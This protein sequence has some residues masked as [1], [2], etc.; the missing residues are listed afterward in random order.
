LA[1]YD[2]NRK[3]I[4]QFLQTVKNLKIIPYD[5]TFQDLRGV[6]LGRINSKKV[7]FRYILWTT[8]FDDYDSIIHL[9]ADTIVLGPLEDLLFREDFF[10]VADF[11]LGFDRL[12][13]F[14]FRN[15]KKLIKRLSDDS[16]S[17][18]PCSLQMM[19]AGIFV[20]QKKYRT[21]EQF[22]RLWHFTKRYNAYSQFADQ[23]AISLWC[24]HNKI[25]F[26]LEIEYNFQI[27]FLLN[28]TVFINII[29]KKNFSVDR[30]KI[31]HYTWWKTESAFYK[32][33]IECA[34]FIT[35]LDR[36]VEAMRI[37]NKIYDSN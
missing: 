26:S 35:T 2:G 1:F 37:S 13:D 19:N 11:T 20:I 15:D 5:E 21:T 32:S 33:F 25:P 9:D 17:T 8:F 18:D 3:P 36:K 16:L 23:A 4:K 10:C 30:L 27:P 7:Y 14:K 28:S 29:A 31:M 22:D 6:N 12:F 24:Y 34:K